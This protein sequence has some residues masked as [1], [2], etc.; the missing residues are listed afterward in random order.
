MIDIVPL[1]GLETL[2][3]GY[4]ITKREGAADSSAGC[5][6]GW[7]ARSDLARDIGDEPEDSRS[8][9][10][11]SVDDALLVEPANV[12]SPRHR[13]LTAAISDPPSSGIAAKSAK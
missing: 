5:L 9:A 4:P 10:R 1:R 12:A 13:Y 7:Y 3:P 6:G 8:I 2:A 11:P